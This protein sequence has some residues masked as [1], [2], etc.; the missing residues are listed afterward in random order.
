LTETTQ[1]L[2]SEIQSLQA[3]QKQLKADFAALSAELST[4]QLRESIAGL[5]SERDKIKAR[6]EPLKAGTVQPVS[7]EERDQVVAEVAKWKKLVD[8][9]K[10]IVKEVWGVIAD[11]MGN[12]E[13]VDL[14]AMKEGFGM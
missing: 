1:S 5:E 6:L 12:A 14:V 13:G 8:R 9:R 11:G 10:K 3:T 4:E 2:R 7:R